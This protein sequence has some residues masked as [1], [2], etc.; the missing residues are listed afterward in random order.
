MAQTQTDNLFIGIQTGFNGTFIISA[1]PNNPS[2]PSLPTPNPSLPTRVDS[3]NKVSDLGSS[4]PQSLRPGDGI[5]D[6]SRSITSANVD[7]GESSTGQD[8]K[9]PSPTGSETASQSQRDGQVSQASSV[10][11]E[12]TFSTNEIMFMSPVRGV[13]RTKWHTTI[14]H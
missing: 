3:S 14:Q 1:A 6:G 12:S 10:A 7:S 5:S 13:H 2:D 11:L 8:P 9:D 4:G